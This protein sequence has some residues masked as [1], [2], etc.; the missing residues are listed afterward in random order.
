MK[1]RATNLYF[2]WQPIAQVITNHTP[3]RCR[4]VL[5]GMLANDP[6]ITKTI[7]LLKAKWTKIYER[8]I[9]GKEIKDEQPW[10]TMNYDLSSFMEYFITQLQLGER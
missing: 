9:V 3:E 1:A 8:G 10:E 5:S 6:N 2:F 7:E 4:R